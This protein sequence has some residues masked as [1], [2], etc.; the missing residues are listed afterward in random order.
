MRHARQSGFCRQV[1]DASDCHF[2]RH[3]NRDDVEAVDHRVAQR[4]GLH[5]I[6]VA[7]VPRRVFLIVI[8][9]CFRLVFV[10]SRGR[11]Q[12]WYGIVRGVQR[13]RIHERFES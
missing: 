6:L 13:G 7:H 2:H 12:A 9:E 8:S 4:Y 11:D 1:H 5:R 3:V 10:N